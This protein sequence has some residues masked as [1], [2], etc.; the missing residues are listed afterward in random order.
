[1]KTTKIIFSILV[2]SFVSSLTFAASHYVRPGLTYNGDGTTW[3]A[4]SSAGGAGA[5]NALPADLIRGDTYYLADGNYG[6]YRFNDAASGS[7][8]IY[9]KK[10][11]AGAHGTA[12]GWNNSYGDGQAIF[13][14]GAGQNAII[15]T[16]NYWDIDG[17]TGY[18]DGSVQQHGIKL[19]MQ[20][21]SARAT[22]L[23][24][25]TSY[26]NLRHLDIGN[27]GLDLDRDGN[28]IYANNSS[29]GGV[30]QNIHYCYLHDS[31]T[32]LI[33]SRRRTNSILEY[34]Y[35]ARNSSSSSR[36]AEGWSDG[37][38]TNIIC[39]YNQFFDIEGS[40]YI[41]FPVDAVSNWEIYGNVFAYTAQ[42]SSGRGG[43]S[44][45]IGADSSGYITGFKVYNNSFVRVRSYNSALRTEPGSS[46]NYAYNNLW[47]GC[48]DRDGSGSTAYVLNSSY[49]T[50]DYN[51]F[52]D[53]VSV[54]EAHL[55]ENVPT[56]I[57]TNYAGDDLTLARATDRGM[58]LPSPYN[59]DMLG[60]TRG[61]DQNW[62]RGAYEFP[63]ATQGE[64]RPPTNLRVLQ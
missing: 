17:V 22:I 52:S 32:S 48:V 59:T 47:V 7:T 62:D 36:H 63:V 34:C 24:S 9:I 58:T 64:I 50:H 57:F 46:N 25:N 45:V 37:G 35:L 5:Y 61:S 4:A 23:M 55:Q 20:P 51:A 33:V 6:T 11:T 3:A 41:S 39:R 16:T 56:S 15:I 2:M 49:V 43:V 29:G 40:A 54:S 21:D 8:Y 30:S 44:W 1:M 53:D 13:A 28:C 14:A 27:A 31:T 38:S 10:A 12:T 42:N 18:N 60:S 19:T 26:V